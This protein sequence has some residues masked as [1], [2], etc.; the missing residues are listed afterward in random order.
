MTAA[1]MKRSVLCLLVL[2]V[3]AIPACSLL[4]EATSSFQ[5]PAGGG[6]P[7]LAGG[8]AITCPAGSIAASWREPFVWD[9]APLDWLRSTELFADG[10]KDDEGRT[11][12][13]VLLLDAR[14]T[15]VAE[16]RFEHGKGDGAWTFL[17]PDGRRAV[18]AGFSNGVQHGRTTMWSRTGAK[19]AE[20]DWVDGFLHGYYREWYANG[21]MAKEIRYR[22]G[23]PAGVGRSWHENGKLRSRV[24]YVEGKIQGVMRVYDD[25]GQ[26]IEAVHYDEGR[27]VTGAHSL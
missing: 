3:P 10:C 11:H 13:P 24:P 25:N 20:S 9:D 5:L 26:L 1:R 27:V 15:L 2:C 4:P 23:E 19:I 16:G 22:Q 21:R 17:Y 18:V 6:P 7:M 8:K 14:R 12:G